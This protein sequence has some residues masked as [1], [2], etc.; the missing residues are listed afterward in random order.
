MKL[1][2]A[3]ESS[4]RLRRPP[5]AAQC[6]RGNKVGGVD[7]GADA[8][9]ARGRGY[10][11]RPVGQRPGGDRAADAPPPL[12]GRPPLRRP[13]RR[14]PGRLLRPRRQGPDLDAGSTFGE[15]AAIDRKPRSANVA[16]LT[17]VLVGS[18]PAA[19]FMALM[20]Q[21]PSVAEAGLV[22]LADLLRALSQRL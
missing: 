17:D 4:Q 10:P 15:L 13:P 22:K 14:V 2:L 5:E 20:R 18:I 19:E 9:A 8:T 12:A 11:G 7:V 16:A 3:Q 21:Y 6:G 1:T